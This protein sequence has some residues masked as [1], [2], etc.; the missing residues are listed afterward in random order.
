MIS[1]DTAKKLKDEGLKW[2]PGYAD[3]YS[4]NGQT[5]VVSLSDCQSP[6]GRAVLR[7][8][9]SIFMP[10]L[11]QLLVE[12]ERAG[13]GFVIRRSDCP[14]T[15]LDYKSYMSL[16]KW[17]DG[18]SVKVFE[19]WDLAAEEAAAAALIWILE[20]EGKPDAE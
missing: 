6:T 19:R 20:Q 16:T 7:S 13:C 3:F 5:Y 1:L 11:D 12:I 4:W 8:K 17:T 18:D 9:D 2:E 14:E 10:R 15:Y